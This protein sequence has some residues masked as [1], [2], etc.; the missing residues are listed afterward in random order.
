MRKP[1]CRKRG[2]SVAEEIMAGNC[3]KFKLH[4]KQWLSWN[5]IYVVH[6]A[7]LEVTPQRG[8]RGIEIYINSLIQ[9]YL[10]FF[11]LPSFTASY[12]CHLSPIIF[13]VLL[14]FTLFETSKVGLFP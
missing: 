9:F 6:P 3:G 10:F 4:S 1:P 13:A 2:G 12:V 8:L 11:T 14:Y 5:N 7:Q